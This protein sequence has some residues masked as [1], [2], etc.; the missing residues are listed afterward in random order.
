MVVIPLYFG[1]VP[2]EE[3]LQSFPQSRDNWIATIGDTLSFAT[4]L[5][6]V[7]KEKLGLLGFSMGGHLALWRAK[8]TTP[9]KVN[10]VVEFFA[11]INYPPIFTGIGDN[12]KN[13]PN[14][15]IHHGTSDST[16]PLEQT[17]LLRTLLLAAGKVEGTDF[18]I[19]TYPG[20][21]HGFVAHEAIASSQAASAEF[22]RK[23]L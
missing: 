19:I 15:L 23:H 6:N 16:V 13:L 2:A 4:T 17:M 5:K 22:V 14:L 1:E 10:A 12:L 8:S 20:E 9:P 7:R 18:E 3:A 11:P 21:G